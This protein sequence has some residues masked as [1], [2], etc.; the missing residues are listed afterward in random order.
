MEKRSFEDEEVARILNENFISIKVDREERP[1]I[2]SIYMEVCQ[3]LTG[4]EVAIISV[5][6]T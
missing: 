5:F 4:R 1:D 3:G 2:D 6:N